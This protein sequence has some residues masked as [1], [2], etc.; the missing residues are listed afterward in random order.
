MDETFGMIADELRKQYLIGYYPEQD[1][2]A[3]IL[4]QIRVRTNVQNAVVR[5]KTTYRAQQPTQ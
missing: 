2:N 1:A 4:H 5:S 3:G